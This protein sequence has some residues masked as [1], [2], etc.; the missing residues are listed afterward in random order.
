VTVAIYPLGRRWEIV[1]M[2]TGN[3]TLASS[4]ETARTALRAEGLFPRRPRGAEEC[5]ALEVWE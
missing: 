4:L 5:G 3:V 2:E 1:E